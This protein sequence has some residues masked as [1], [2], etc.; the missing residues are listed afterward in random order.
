MGSAI[1]QGSSNSKRT[2]ADQKEKQKTTINSDSLIVSQK[3][4]MASQKISKNISNRKRT[5]KKR[6]S[7]ISATSSALDASLS[8]FENMSIQ[9]ENVFG[10]TEMQSATQDNGHLNWKVNDMSSEMN[11]EVRNFWEHP[12]L[13]SSH[14]KRSKRNKLKNSSFRLV[15]LAASTSVNEHANA[16]ARCNEPDVISLSGK[17]GSENLEDDAEFTLVEKAG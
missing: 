2:A 17:E 15:T 14:E 10:H 4:R 3:S 1:A 13:G 16:V 5:R 8:R 12:D 9:R 6:T 7:V 11:S